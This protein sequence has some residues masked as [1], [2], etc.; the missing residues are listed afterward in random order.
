MSEQKQGSG[1]AGLIVLFVLYCICA[2]IYQGWLWLDRAGYRSHVVGSRI[3]AEQE[4][5]PGETKECV[6][7]PLLN[8][9][10]HDHPRGDLFGDIDCDSGP[11]H[12]VRIEFYG[13]QLQPELKLSA[14]WRCTRKPISSANDAAFVCRQTGAS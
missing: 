1:F 2:G 5:L 6:S 14:S 7:T 4:W 10:E 3:T 9:E 8:A 11:K 12:N 13:R